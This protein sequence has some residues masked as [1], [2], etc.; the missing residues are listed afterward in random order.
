MDYKIT[1]HTGQT[2][3]VTDER[4]LKDLAASLCEAGHVIVST[5][6]SDYAGGLTETVFL[7]RAVM[8]I[9]PFPN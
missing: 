8:T 3:N 1:L 6:R 7:E 9:E 4:D 5:E 2:F